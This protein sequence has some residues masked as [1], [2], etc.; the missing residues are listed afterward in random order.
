MKDK[1]EF[2]FLEFLISWKGF[3]LLI[4]IMS[5]TLF[6]VIELTYNK[7]KQLNECYNSGVSI[8]NCVFEDKK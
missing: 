6:F 5:I 2:K 4:I 8:N 3:L 7:L 1:F